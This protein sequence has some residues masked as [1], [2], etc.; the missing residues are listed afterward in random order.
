MGKIYK[1][2]GYFKCR[3]FPGEFS[4]IQLDEETISATEFAYYCD[5][6]LTFGCYDVR[7]PDCWYLCGFVRAGETHDFNERK[8]PVSVN[9]NEFFVD[10]HD[11]YEAFG[12][13]YLAYNRHKNT[14][15]AVVG[16][17]GFRHPK[18]N[19]EFDIP[20]NGIFGFIDEKEYNIIGETV[21]RWNEKILQEMKK[22]KPKRREL[23][24]YL[25]DYYNPII[26]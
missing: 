23:E 14:L 7:I 8:F 26:V 6:K 13:P 9:G 22:H 15:T 11:V 12:Y 24:A 1:N 2:P 16:Y 4:P 21:N 19:R 25:K 18:Q 10:F 3:V 20:T 17:P 5:V